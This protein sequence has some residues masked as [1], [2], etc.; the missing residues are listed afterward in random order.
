MRNIADK[1]WSRKKNSMITHEI[2]GIRFQ[3]KTYQDLTWLKKYG[4][5]FSV[6]DATGS[7]CICFGVADTNG[8]DRYFIKIAGA[9]T[10]DAEIAPA[11][12]VEILKGAA[13]LYRV[14]K[15]SSLVELLSHYSYRAYYVAVFRWVEGECLFDHW[16]FDQYNKTPGLVSPAVRFHSL[17]VEKKLSAAEHI[18]SFLETVAA[19]RYVAVDFYDGS[20]IYDFKADR[21][22]ICDIDLFRKQP[23]YNDMGEGYWGSKR[24]KAPEEYVLGAAI[25]ERTNVFTAGALLF[26]F[27]G[28][29]TQAEIEDRYRYRRVLPCRIEQWELGKEAY[30][31][32][33]KAI[34]PDREMR[35]QTM[36]Q[37]RRAFLEAVGWQ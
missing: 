37:F 1:T 20:L 32:V 3:L 13:E 24:M 18:F 31:A 5:V 28:T 2:D 21:M 9:D 27:F 15:H 16:N 12:S 30:A 19:K 4:T 11:K 33:S 36:A 23:A 35:Y 7:G 14:L 29:Y 6:I 17:P 8:R 10:M 34:S 22:M 26:G 25:D